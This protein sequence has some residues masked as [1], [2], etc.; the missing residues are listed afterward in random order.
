MIPDSCNHL[1]PLALFALTMAGSP[2]PN[3][4]MLTASGANFGFRR[5]IPHILGIILGMASM[6]LGLAAGLNVL[7]EEFPIIHQGLKVVGALFLFYL[8]WRIATAQGRLN[9]ESADGRP[10][11]LLEAMLFQFVNPKAWL[12]NISAL[13]TFSTAGPEYWH[14]AL[15]IVLVFTLVMLNTLPFWT[16]FGVFV[17]RLLS[18]PRALKRFNLGMGILTAAS[19]VLILN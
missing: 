5:S 14:S 18:T 10:L 19:V 13:A 9:Q 8:A 17:G 7:F 12:I 6:L 4:L 15:W 11:T 2:G 16:S 1:L 3:N